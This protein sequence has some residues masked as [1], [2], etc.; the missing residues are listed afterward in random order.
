MDHTDGIPITGSVAESIADILIR[1]KE[2]SNNESMLPGKPRSERPIKAQ[3]MK[4]DIEGQPEAQWNLPRHRGA[5][6]TA[7]ECEV[8][9]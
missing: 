1:V 5:P 9:S 6:V 7:G 2:I 3:S 8:H 4:F